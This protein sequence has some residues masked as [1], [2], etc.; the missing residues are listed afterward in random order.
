[1][2]ARILS[3]LPVLVAAGCSQSSAPPPEPPS[4]PPEPPEPLVLRVEDSRPLLY[5]WRDPE[6]GRFESAESPDA[7]PEEARG[8]VIV[9]DLSVSPEARG[10]AGYVHVADLRTRRPDGTHPVAVQSRYGFGAPSSGRPGAGGREGV[11]LY[12]AAWCGVCKKAERLLSRWQVP[13]QKKDI[14]ASRSA[15]EELSAKAAAAGIR[16]GG[17]PVIDVNGVLLQGLDE[18]RLRA[19]LE[20]AGLLPKS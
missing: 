10:S 8:A 3:V 5:T 4:A 20:R 17:V 18:A 12:S 19:E 1:M 13:F 9:T 2:F 11:V 16:P 6:T 15:M 14:E 7:V